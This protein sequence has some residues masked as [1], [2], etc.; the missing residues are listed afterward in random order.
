M[1]KYIFSIALSLSNL[2]YAG[3][4]GEVILPSDSQQIGIWQNNGVGRCTRSIDFSKSQ[5]KYYMVY[6]CSDGG[7]GKEG[8]VLHRFTKGGLDAF[9]KTDQGRYG[10]YYVIESNGS[11]GIYDNQGVI[12]TLPSTKI[13]WPK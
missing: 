10:D 6:R 3:F 11:L 13:L 4:G 2:S 1:K 7:G 5:K 9:K 12:D 8:A